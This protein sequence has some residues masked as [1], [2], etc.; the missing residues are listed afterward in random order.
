MSTL[1]V[2]QSF[3]ALRKNLLSS[4]GALDLK[5]S[6]MITFNVDNYN[7]RLSHQLVFQIV[8]RVV[9]R[10]VRWTVLDEV[11]STLKR[12][13]KLLLWV[14]MNPYMMAFNLGFM[15]T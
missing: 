9:G 11:A 12:L 1:E 7:S 2:L 15:D 4:L 6:T 8:T 13:L 5:N 14:H 3:L 10:K